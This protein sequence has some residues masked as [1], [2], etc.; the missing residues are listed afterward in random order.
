MAKPNRVRRNKRAADKFK[1][2]DYMC[3]KNTEKPAA[4]SEQ[5]EELIK[6]RT[7]AFGKVFDRIIDEKMTDNDMRII[8]TFATRDGVMSYSKNQEVTDLADLQVEELTEFEFESIIK[9]ANH[10]INIILENR[11]SYTEGPY[12]SN[13]HMRRAA[14]GAGRRKRGM[15]PARTTNAS[16]M[17]EIQKGRKMMRR[18]LGV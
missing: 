11:T 18:A 3:C 8:A 10:A 12:Y 5:E 4:E 17:V 13:R 16:K 14:V 9:R 6:R 7:E 1:T 2:K 15:K